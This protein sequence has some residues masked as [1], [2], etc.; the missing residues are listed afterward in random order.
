MNTSTVNCEGK[1]LVDIETGRVLRADDEITVTERYLHSH[2]FIYHVG[3]DDTYFA[4]PD[5]QRRARARAAGEGELN[6]NA[7]EYTAVTRVAGAVTLQKV[8][9]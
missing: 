6:L 2:P 9:D 8:E 3:L 7:V 4:G 1:L 5:A